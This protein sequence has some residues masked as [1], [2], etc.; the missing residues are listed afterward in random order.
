MSVRIT[1]TCSPMARQ[2]REVELVLPDGA[3]AGDALRASGLLEI[4][5][6][7]AEGAEIGVWGRKA[8]LDLALQD[9]DRLEIYRPLR[10]DPKTAR[11]ERFKLQGSRTAGLFA[12]RSRDS[13][14]G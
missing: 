8:A 12:S 1:V 5:G 2:T 4:M 13:K 14:D 7:Q 9:R 10:V 11:R 3:T 6:L